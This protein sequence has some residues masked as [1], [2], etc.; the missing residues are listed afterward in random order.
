MQS[1]ISRRRLLVWEARRWIGTRE[2]GGANRGQDVERFQRSVDG[3][4]EG[5][6]WCVSFAQ[7]CVKQADE[8]ADWIEGPVIARRNRLM[9]TEHT[10]TL[11]NGTAQEARLEDPVPGCLVLWWCFRDGKPSGAGHCGVVVDVSTGSIMTVEGNTSDGKGIVREGVG[12]F[13]RMRS[14]GVA[15]RASGD[16]RLLGFLDPWYNPLKLTPPAA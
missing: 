16:M 6:P 11:W 8:L 3:R 13:E 9:Q 1:P 14:T 2:I 7:F 5:E 10:L 4:A 15:A 12:V